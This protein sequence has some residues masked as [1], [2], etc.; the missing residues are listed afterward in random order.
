MALLSD[1]RLEL[2]TSWG[3]IRVTARA[4]R[5]LACDLPKRARRVAAPLTVHRARLWVSVEG[6]RAVLKQ[7]ERFIR[8]ALEGRRARLPPLAALDNAP[9]FSAC[10]RALLRI[11]AGRTVT[12]HELARQAGRPAAIR[13]AGQACARNPLPLFVPC[14]RV[15]ATGGRLGGFS[16]GPA[17][18]RHLLQVEAPQ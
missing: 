2:W 12:Y 14:H 1:S 15:L 6:D 17:W 16:A 4:G 9:F 7:A 11:P 8:A 5:L 10:R 13:A 3:P 18:K